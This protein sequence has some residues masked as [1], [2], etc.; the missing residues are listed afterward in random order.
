MKRR[1]WLALSLIGFSSGCLR[2]T[3]SQ[4]PQSTPESRATFEVQVANEEG[5]LQTVITGSDVATASNP[6]NKKWR[7]HYTVNVELAESGA[8]KLVTTLEEVDA[9]NNRQEHPIFVYFDGQ[10][11]H[12]FQ[13]SR[14]LAIQMRS[15]EFQHNRTIAISL[16][17]RHVARDLS[18]SL[19][20]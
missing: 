20:S 7:S 17:D 6:H 15:G 10:N 13:L 9:F 16:E 11:V 14:E 4:P 8:E 18:D 3:E 2:L 19:Q 1:R 12:S 5:T